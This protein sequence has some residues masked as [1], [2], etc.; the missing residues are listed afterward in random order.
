M[1]GTS[2]DGIDLAYI[3]FHKGYQWQADLGNAPPAYLQNGGKSQASPVHVCYTSN[4]KDYS[5]LGPP[6][7]R[8]HAR[9]F[10][11]ARCTSHGHT[12]W[13]QLEKVSPYKLAMDTSFKPWPKHPLSAILEADE[14]GEKGRHWYPLVINFGEYTI[15]SIW[16]LATTFSKDGKRRALTFAQPIWH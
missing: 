3:E 6:P 1:S 13:H 14:T 5:Q 10:T 8:L 11:K 15:A 12:V 2:L 9:L 16:V 7:Q 4:R